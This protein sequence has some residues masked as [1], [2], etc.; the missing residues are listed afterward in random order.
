MNDSMRSITLYTHTQSRDVQLEELK[1]LTFIPA[2]ACERRVRAYYSA[3]C[4]QVL[5]RLRKQVN[6]SVTITG[7][8]NPVPVHDPP[9]VWQAN[10]V[11]FSNDP[12]N[13]ALG[14]TSQTQSVIITIEICHT[15]ISQF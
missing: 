10:I 1:M 2:A 3:Q 4:A 6:V 15:L 13:V 9:C 12:V 14:N 5:A 8:S 7:G 11:L